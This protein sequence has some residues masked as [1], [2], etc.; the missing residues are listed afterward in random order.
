MGTRGP[1]APMPGRNLGSISKQITEERKMDLASSQGLALFFL[2]GCPSISAYGVGR[3]ACRL[4]CVGSES[5]SM[6]VVQSKI[7]YSVGYKRFIFFLI[8]SCN[9]LYTVH[10]YMHGK[11][12]EFGV[13]P[14]L[15]FSQRY[16]FSFGKSQGATLIVVFFLFLPDRDYFSNPSCQCCPFFLSL[17]E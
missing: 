6:G 12:C 16:W 11:D 7:S 10:V 5:E 9:S 8:F 14:G 17:H 4:G 1:G 3:G 13:M 15:W 2:S